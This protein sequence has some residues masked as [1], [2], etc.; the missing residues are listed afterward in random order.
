M[1]IDFIKLMASKSEE[2][3]QEYLDNRKKYTPEAVFA[4]IEEFKKRGRAFTEEEIEKIK[5]DVEKQKEIN[6]QRA[7]AS[8]FNSNRLGRNVVK[9]A[10]A[11]QYYSERAIYMF[12][13]LFSVLFGSILMAIN[14]NKTDKK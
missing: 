7:A 14:L 13:T 3:L 12:S 4:A 10:D 5:T 1:E 9:D 2:G 11:P 8:P 6:E